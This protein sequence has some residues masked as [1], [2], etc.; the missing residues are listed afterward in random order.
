MATAGSAATALAAQ[1]GSGRDEDN[2]GDSDVGGHSQQSTKRG[3]GGD[4]SGGNGDGS[5][6]SDSDETVMIEAAGWVNSET[7]PKKYC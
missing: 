6:N 1:D 4:I 5:G 3:S 2:G 7:E